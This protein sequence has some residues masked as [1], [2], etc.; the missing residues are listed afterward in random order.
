[1]VGYILSALLAM[2]PLPG[3]SALPNGAEVRVV[4]TDL[5][6][7]YFFWRVERGTLELQA[8]PLEIPSGSRVRLLIRTGRKLYAYEGRFI[9]DDIYV[10]TDSGFISIKQAFAEVYHLKWPEDADFEAPANASNNRQRQNRGSSG[11]ARNG[12]QPADSAKP[13]NG[14]GGGN[15]GHGGSGTPGSGNPGTGSGN[16]SGNGSGKGAKGGHGAGKQNIES[17][18]LDTPNLTAPEGLEI[19]SIASPQNFK[20]NRNDGE[21][22]YR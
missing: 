4:S 6:T 12:E 10:E 5:R 9:D 2:V 11:P 7:V 20:D 15:S 1:M 3:L 17:D 8:Q 16:G 19:Q 14:S 18:S 21:P 22:V 13:G